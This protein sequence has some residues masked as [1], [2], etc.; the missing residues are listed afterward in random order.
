MAQEHYALF[1]RLVLTGKVEHGLA[2]SK[3]AVVL[4]LRADDEFL[5]LA[6]SGT[7]RNE[8]TCYHVL[9]HTFQTV[10]LTT[11]GSLVE[12]LC[13]LLE[14]CGRDEALGLQRRTSDA[15]EYLCGCCGD[16]VTHLNQT[17]VT[18]LETRVLVAQLACGDDLT[19]LQCFGVARIGHIFL[20]PYAV[21]L[22]GEVELVHHLLLEE[23]GIARLVYLNLAHHLAHDNLEVL[24]VNL[25]TL[26]TVYV[27]NLVDDVFLNRS[28]T[29]DGEDVQ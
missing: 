13:C 11:Y 3:D 18:T 28:G 4:F 12:H 16:G 15:L 21:V 23:R 7:G 17:E 24:V 26:Q 1:G 2:V 29:L 10:Y 20:A 19:H 25:H 14:R 27:L 9:L 5:P 6:E 8:V 22:L